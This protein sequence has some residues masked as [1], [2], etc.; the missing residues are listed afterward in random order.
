MTPRLLTREDARAVNELRVLMGFPP[1]EFPAPAPVVPTLF[2]PEH[3]RVLHNRMK[4]AVNKCLRGRIASSSWFERVGYTLD[5]L[6]A[7]LEA[8]FT[9][10]MSWANLGAWHIDHIRPL[11][12]FTIA[13]LDCP[14]FK[15]AWALANLQPLW[16][17][18]N[19][20]KGARW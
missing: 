6:K 15:A 2:L 14:E 18:D 4:V 13:G 5:E 7:H 8:Q 12:S 1:R 9:D 19:L 3:G 20:S 10:G 11:A 17:R 16:K